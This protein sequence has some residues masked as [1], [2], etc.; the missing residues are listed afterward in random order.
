MTEKVSNIPTMDGT[1]YRFT[2][3]VSWDRELCFV[4]PELKI[5]KDN[6][7]CRPVNGR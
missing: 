7:E 3:P 6:E 5:E 2:I 4:G 1:Y